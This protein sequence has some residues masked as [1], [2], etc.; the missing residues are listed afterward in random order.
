MN[1]SLKI[2]KFLFLII[3]DIYYSETKP[4]IYQNSQIKE[5]SVIFIKID[6]TVIMSEKKLL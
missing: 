3:A 6:F 5:P 2:K 1:Y 4:C